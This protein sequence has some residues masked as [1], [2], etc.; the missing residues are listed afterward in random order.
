MVFL[1][2]FLLPFPLCFPALALIFAMGLA[3]TPDKK[4][5]L[6]GTVHSTPF[7]NAGCVVVDVPATVRSLMAAFDSS[8]AGLA[9]QVVRGLARQYGKFEHVAFCLDNA[10]QMHSMRARVAAQRTAKTVPLTSEETAEVAT[11]Q[12]DVLGPGHLTTVMPWG[13]LLR[14]AA[15]KQKV[16]EMMGRALFAAALQLPHIKG[17]K[18]VGPGCEAETGWGTFSETNPIV[19]KTIDFDMMLQALLGMDA[20]PNQ[21]HL[22]FKSVMLDA[23]KLQAL[24]GG[25]NVDYRLTAAFWLL[26]AFKSDYSKPICRTVGMTTKKLTAHMKP[27]AQAQ[28]C[29]RET[30]DP[31]QIVFYPRVF[32][33]ALDHKSKKLPSTDALACILWTLV[34]FRMYDRTRDVASGPLAIT[35]PDDVYTDQTCIVYSDTSTDGGAE[36]YGE[37]DL[38]VASEVER[39][40]AS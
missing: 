18:V 9:A 36:F 17:V 22:D 28:C 14:T 39:L 6:F 26:C 19:V 27:S 12:L 2:V 15:L 34:Y 4:K 38:M 1:T 13:L 10:S 7:D 11:L 33:A 31:R 40:L 16:W 23:G 25:D 29:V 20:A 8:P 37:A 5:M 24:Y 21:L 30:G 32:I 3:I 35:L